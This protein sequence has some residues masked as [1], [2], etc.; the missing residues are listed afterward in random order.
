MALSGIRDLSIMET[1]PENRLPIKTYVGAYDEHLIREA[2]IREMERNGQVFF[3]HNRIY[4]ISA[5]AEKLRSL[6]PEAK[7]S[8][9]HGRLQEELEEI[10]ADFALHKSDVLLTTTI[11]ESGLDMP[12]V[13][14]LII[15]ES[16]KLGLTQLYQLRGRVGRGDLTAYSY[17]LFNGGK[18]LTPQ[19]KKRLKA[20]A[21]ASEL[22]AGFAIAMKDLEIRGSGNLLGAEQS[23]HIAAIGFDLYCKLLTEAVEEAKQK[24]AGK[25][26]PD[27]Q[28]PRIPSIALPL[29]Y[30]IPGTFISDENIRIMF[31]K[32]LA[33]AQNHKDLQDIS[34]ELKDRFGDL[35]TAVIDLLYMMKMKLLA[36]MAK[37][38]SISSKGQQIIVQFH[39]EVV[40]F[41]ITD[42]P[43]K[44][45]DCMRIGTKQITIE[46][47]YAKDGWQE[48]L[49]GLLEKMSTTIAIVTKY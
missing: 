15:D 5:V 49:Q 46:I 14:T 19:A 39:D 37:V 29:V 26:G 25:I 38:E 4:N 6:V 34:D 24:R 12:N 1:P 17:F 33:A 30:H 31:Y 2:I 28:L 22:G 42:F 9:A 27:E 44:Y 48:I 36:V 40:R 18:Q 13:N 21:E 23:G 11:I 16:D 8:V 7:I 47:K 32:K 35:P 20:I 43:K 41:D 45:R 10:M 3:I